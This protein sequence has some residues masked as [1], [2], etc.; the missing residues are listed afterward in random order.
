MNLEENIYQ[1]KCLQFNND[2]NF[3]FQDLYQNALPSILQTVK[4]CTDASYRN[5]QCLNIK[6]NAVWKEILAPLA[7]D[8]CAINV[9]SRDCINNAILQYSL[10]F[11]SETYYNSVNVTLPDGISLLDP[12]NS[13]LS[14]NKNSFLQSSIQKLKNG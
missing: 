1:N 10:P 7:K 12:I 2:R 6:I 13:H 5:I 3:I 14:R 11:P 4:R 9:L 8:M